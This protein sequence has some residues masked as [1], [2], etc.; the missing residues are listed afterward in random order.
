MPSKACAK[1]R[2][3]GFV[4]TPSLFGPW[5]GSLG[6]SLRTG[7]DLEMQETETNSPV[8]G[9]DVSWKAM[10]DYLLRVIKFT[11]LARVVGNE[12]QSAES[13]LP[14][15]ILTVECLELNQEFVVYLTHKVDFL[16]L[17]KVFNERG[18]SEEEEVLVGDFASKRSGFFRIFS[19]FLPRLWVWI[20]RRGHLERL[21]N[22]DW[23]GLTG[24]AWANA[25]MPL[26][27]WEPPT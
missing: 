6:V 15:G 25:M 24:E 13:N 4:V 12:I 18:I 27:M 16:H 20:C 11:P 7:V 3:S 1:G 23:D 17:W 2:A 5:P 22:D 14:Y 26:E 9:K 21:V 10:N 8:I 19:S